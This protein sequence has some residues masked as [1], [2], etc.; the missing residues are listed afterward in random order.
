M[1]VKVPVDYR[2]TFKW[3]GDLDAVSLLFV[4]GGGVV[5][6]HTLFSASMGFI[7][8]LAIAIV[9]TGL[10][11]LLGLGRW[12][13]E[14][15][16]GAV[17]WFRRGFEYR[18]RGHSFRSVRVLSVAEAVRREATYDHESRADAPPR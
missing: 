9:A 17:M 7:P 15:G 13:I 5:G 18:S 6:L 16:D 12:P 8:R 14:H 10:G 2:Q 11:A 3:V 1:Q 4:G